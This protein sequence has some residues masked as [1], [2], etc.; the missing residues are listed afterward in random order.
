[1]AFEPCA[2][3]VEHGGPATADAQRFQIACS[4]RLIDQA[5]GHAAAAHYFG[6]AER[7]WFGDG[8][9]TNY[10]R[11]RWT[12]R[13]ILP[14]VWSLGSFSSLRG[15]ATWLDQMVRSNVAFALDCSPLRI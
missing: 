7:E 1:M 12:M 9:H 4:K 14:L 13:M 5:S 2:E 3:V 8:V 15:L 6:N 10:L 11:L